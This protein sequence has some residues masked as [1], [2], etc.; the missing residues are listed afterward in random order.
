MVV[1][2]RILDG[3]AFLST[4]RI[5]CLFVRPPHPNKQT[6]KQT[7]RNEVTEFIDFSGQSCDPEIVQAS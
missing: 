5:V 6:N 2:G 7:F 3:G 1:I 4:K